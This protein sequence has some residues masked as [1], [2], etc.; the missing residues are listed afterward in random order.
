MNNLPRF[1]EIDLREIWENAKV[2]PLIQPYFP[3]KILASRRPPNRTFL[4]TVSLEGC[5][6]YFP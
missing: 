3:D 1:P 6:N 4:F 2:S 5:F